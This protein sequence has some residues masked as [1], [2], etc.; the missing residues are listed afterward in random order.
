[1]RL[2]RSQWYLMP[3]AISHYKLDFI[4]QFFFLHYPV[5]KSHLYCTV[6]RVVL[7]PFLV[8]LLALC[9]FSVISQALQF[10]KVSF[11]KKINIYFT[12]DN[13]KNCIYHIIN[14][15]IYKN[16]IIDNEK[17]EHKMQDAWFIVISLSQ[18]Y[19]KRN[20]FRQCRP[21]SCIKCPETPISLL[22]QEQQ[23]WQLQ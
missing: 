1:M 13:F 21:R 11:V 2:D 8:S 17:L 3:G 23:W 10:L 9:F 19:N 7:Q 18:G 5:S 16:K 14:N 22:S 15:K 4:F 12:K 6:L 20:I